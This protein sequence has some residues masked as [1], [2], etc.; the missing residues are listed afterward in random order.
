M[1]KIS[2]GLIAMICMVFSVIIIANGSATTTSTTTTTAWTTIDPSPSTTTTITTTP[3]SPI[4][5][6]IIDSFQT[7]LK[8]TVPTL[9]GTQRA[10]VFVAFCESAGTATLNSVSYG[11]RPMT[12]IVQRSVGTSSQ[13]YV[14]AFILNDANIAAATNDTFVV[15]WSATPAEVTY[16]HVFLKNVSQ[17]NPIGATA[18]NST[19]TGTPNPLTAPGLT[20]RSGDLIVAAAD[21]GTRSTYTWNNYFTKRVQYQLPTSTASA[22]TKK[23]A[24]FSDTA[25]VTFYGTFTNEVLIGFVVRLTN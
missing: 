5:V 11:G 21:N 16:T 3:P 17:S 7:G 9:P 23:G 19:A 4:N 8:H 10:L 2:L 22:A 13:N 1:N 14:A 15:S 18:S 20:A 24:G 6:E 12:R 25:S